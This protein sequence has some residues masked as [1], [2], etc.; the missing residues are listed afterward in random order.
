MRAMQTVGPVTGKPFWVV[1]V[2]RN[3]R[4]V[5][6]FGRSWALAARRAIGNERVAGA[7]R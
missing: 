6:G 2:M 1:Q 4:L 7:Q 5:T 3:G